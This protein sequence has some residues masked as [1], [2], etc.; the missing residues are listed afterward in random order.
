MTKKENVKLEDVAI[1]A[2]LRNSALDA[3][4]SKKEAKVATNNEKDDN[5]QVSRGDEK[6]DIVATLE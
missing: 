2:S 5:K 4:T 1:V 3:S 6:T